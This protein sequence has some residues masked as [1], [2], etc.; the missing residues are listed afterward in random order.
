MHILSTPDSLFYNM[1]VWLEAKR[2]EFVMLIVW[3]LPIINYSTLLYINFLSINNLWTKYSVPKWNRK[4]PSRARV[5]FPMSTINFKKTNINV[6][7]YSF[8]S[9]IK[10]NV[11]FETTNNNEQK[12][13]K[14]SEL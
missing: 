8:V 2:V 6:N 7:V 3:L 9:L 1:N 5:N 11:D 10:L 14:T 12:T 13:K 4:N